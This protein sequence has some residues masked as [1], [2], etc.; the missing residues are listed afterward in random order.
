M[1]SYSAAPFKAMQRV[2]KAWL[3]A[4]QAHSMLE[5]EPMQV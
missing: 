4:E 5:D 2:Y 3:A 1:S